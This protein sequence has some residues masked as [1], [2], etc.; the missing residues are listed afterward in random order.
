MEW[1]VWYPSGMKKGITIVRIC[2]LL[3]LFLLPYSR[4][5][6]APIVFRRGNRTGTIASKGLSALLQAVAE[7]SS[8]PDA[9][10][11]AVPIR[12]ADAARRF[13]LADMVAFSR[14][15]LRDLDAREVLALQEPLPRAAESGPLPED[16]P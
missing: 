11:S 4:A 16:R 6:A 9:I 5:L 12:A 14:I 15:V 13:D 7:Q 3:S 8:S 10:V 1:E 2:V